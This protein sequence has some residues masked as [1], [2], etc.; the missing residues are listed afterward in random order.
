MK[1]AVAELLRRMETEV[2][3]VGD[4]EMVRVEL[5]N[6]DPTLVVEKFMLELIEPPVGYKGREERRGFRLAARKRASEAEVEIQLASGSKNEVMEKLASEEMLQKLLRQA[7]NLSHH[8][9]DLW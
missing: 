9:Q 6:P 8:L 3:E 4:F 1:Q 5:E 2:P 7:R